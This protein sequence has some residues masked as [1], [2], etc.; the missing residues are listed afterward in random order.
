V[1]R[2]GGKSEIRNPK[3]E[4]GFPEYNPRS[5]VQEREIKEGDTMEDA[6]DRPSYEPE[7]V[8]TPTPST[9]QKY[10]AVQRLWMMFTS[11][12]EVFSDIAIKPT[13]LLLIVTLVILGVAYQAVVIPHVDIEETIRARFAEQG[14]EVNEEQIEAAVK[15]T[16]IIARLSPVIIPTMGLIIAALFYFL[17]LKI[18][19]SDADFVHALSTTLHGSWPPTLVQIVL[20][21]AL[22]QR[23][24]KVQPGQLEHLVKANLGAFLSPDIPAWLMAA[25]STVSVFSIWAVI[26]L[27]IGFSTVGKMSRAKAA[28][29][30]LVPWGVWIVAKAALAVVFS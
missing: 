23:I 27:I 11:P 4:I 10:S 15:V 17:M 16:G 13:W 20:T 1:K 14:R 9:K 2:T 7:P 28:V 12:G 6:T 5:E 8:G 3:S 21:G 18:V 22:I 25:A 24:D 19:A 26:L 29:V 30:T